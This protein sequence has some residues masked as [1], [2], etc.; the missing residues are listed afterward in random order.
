MMFGCYVMCFCSICPN[1]CNMFSLF[2]NISFV[3]QES[4]S[5]LSVEYGA[6][7][8]TCTLLQRLRKRLCHIPR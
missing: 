1:A 3:W 6:L 7:V 5:V 8:A 2:T 4:L